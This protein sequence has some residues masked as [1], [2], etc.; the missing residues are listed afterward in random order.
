MITTTHTANILV[1]HR[2]AE[3]RATGHSIRAA[4]Q[5]RMARRAALD[6]APSAAGWTLPALAHHFHLPARRRLG[7]V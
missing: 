2:Q 1:A 3:L 7:L 6:T 5:V 4:R